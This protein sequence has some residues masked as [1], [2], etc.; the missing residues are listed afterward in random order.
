MQWLSLVQHAL[1]ILLY[2]RP[3][4]CDVYGSDATAI[5]CKDSDGEGSLEDTFG[6]LSSIT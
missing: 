2:T 5:C 6:A 3:Y 4:T 1:C